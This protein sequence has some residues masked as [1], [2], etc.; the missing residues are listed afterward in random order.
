MRRTSD[1]RRVQCTFFF[2]LQCRRQHRFDIVLLLYKYLQRLPIF[3]LHR[4]YCRYQ[5]VDQYRA[6][7]QCVYIV[8]ILSCLHRQHRLH[9][10]V[11][12]HQVDKVSTSKFCNVYD[13]KLQKYTCM[14]YKQFKLNIDSTSY[15]LLYR[16]M[17][18]SILF[19]QRR[20]CDVDDV[21]VNEL[22]AMSSK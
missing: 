4:R 19:K 15:K 8:P 14:Q 1:W 22:L 13:V 18:N 10:H 3:C 16:H 11:D 21:Y 6:D 17:I 2:Y 12:R 7:I 5:N 9:R 20:R